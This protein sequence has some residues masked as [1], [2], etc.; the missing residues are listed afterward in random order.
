MTITHRRALTAMPSQS[1]R[2]FY[3]FDAMSP[4]ALKAYNHT[5]L[6]R[7]AEEN[8]LTMVQLFIDHV[9]SAKGEEEMRRWVS[10]K[11]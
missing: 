5:A 11:D 3:V 8:H 9:K 1:T 10:L 2:S 6:D 4:R 7:A